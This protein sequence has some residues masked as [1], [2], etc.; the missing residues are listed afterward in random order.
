MRHPYTRGLFNSIPVPGA[1]KNAR[2]L[3]AIRGQL[4]LPHARPK[5]CY[6]GPRCDL[7]RRR[8]LRPAAAA[9]AAEVAA[10]SGHAVRCVRFDEID[11]TARAR[12]PKSARRSRGGEV[13]LSVD[14][15][16][17][18]LRHRIQRGGADRREKDGQGQREDHLPRPRGRD[19][20]DRRRVRLRQ[21]DLRQGADGAGARVSRQGAARRNSTGEPAGPAPRQEHDLAACR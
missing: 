16:I 3:V 8:A 10:G 13:V 15:P 9:D 14:E 5:G 2:P 4:P 11:W 19:G 21:V 1:D 20:R 7:F 17:Q 12:R 18:A 6:F